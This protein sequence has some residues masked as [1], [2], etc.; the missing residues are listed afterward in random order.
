METI[1]KEDGSTVEVYTADE[2]EAQKQEAIELYK[3]EN[4]D[5]T[6]ELTALQEEL[7]TKEEALEKATKKDLNF[8]TLR[9]QKEAAE[10]KIADITKEIDTKISQAKKEVMEGVMKDHYNDTLKALAGDDEEVKKKIEFHFKRLGDTA[11]TKEEI[12]N[13]LRDAWLLATKPA[14]M[15]AL[16]STVLSSGGVG[17]LK[18]NSSEKKFTPDEKALAQKLAQAGGMKLEES[19]FNK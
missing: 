3:L 18:I 5:K 12:G 7:K 1:T 17:R 2:L 10:K 9:T 19:D 8:G 16:N 13:K 6:D 15:D 4:P 14:E 11:S